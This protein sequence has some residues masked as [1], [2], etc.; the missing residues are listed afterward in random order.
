MG[1]AY[2]HPLRRLFSDLVWQY[3]FVDLQPQDP[4]VAH[5]LSALPTHFTH[6]DSLYHIRNARGKPL[7]TSSPSRR[8]R[9]D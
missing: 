5:D 4:H 6:V 2:D 8:R 7:K 9:G 3:F 1:V